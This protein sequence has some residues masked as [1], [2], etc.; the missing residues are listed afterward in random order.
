MYTQPCFRTR[1]HAQRMW[2]ILFFMQDSFYG[3]K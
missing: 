1:N 2:S 3:M